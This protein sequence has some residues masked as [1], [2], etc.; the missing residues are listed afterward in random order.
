MYLSYVPRNIPV[1]GVS[2]TVVVVVVL[3]VR[4]VDVVDDV[5]VEEVV[6]EVVGSVVVV[7]TIV[8]VVLVEVVVDVVVDVVVGGGTVVVD[9]QILSDV[10]IATHGNFCVP[11]HSSHSAQYESVPSVQL[12]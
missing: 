4:V 7:P 3:V 10:P 6:E 1:V 9:P 11:L 2:G 5:V 8:V 12:K